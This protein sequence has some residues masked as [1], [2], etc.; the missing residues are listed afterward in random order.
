MTKTG[1]GQPLEGHTLDCEQS[2]KCPEV[3]VIDPLFNFVANLLVVLL[4]RQWILVSFY[5][6]TTTSHGLP[7][8]HIMHI[9]ALKHV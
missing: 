1:F 5:A 6:P 7:K 2:P 3:G 4:P 9:S 8:H